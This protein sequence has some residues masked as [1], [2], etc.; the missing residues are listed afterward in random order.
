MT[1]SGEQPSLVLVAAAV[2]L[3]GLSLL[4]APRT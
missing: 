1:G 3:L 4:V 2:V